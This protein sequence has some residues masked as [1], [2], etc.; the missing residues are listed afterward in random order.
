MT[1]RR[2]DAFAP[3]EVGSGA[4]YRLPGHRMMGSLNL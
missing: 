1:F 2:Q 4:P 3:G